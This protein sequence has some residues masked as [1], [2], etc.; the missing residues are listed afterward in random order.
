MNLDGADSLGQ[1]AKCS[2][3][4]WPINGE[5]FVRVPD[6]LTM[7]IQISVVRRTEIARR[8]EVISVT[9]SQTRL[10]PCVTLPAMC[11]RFTRMFQWAELVRLLRL[12]DI[13]P[14]EIARSYNVAPTQ[15]SP[16]AMCNDA[17]RRVGRF[18]RWGLVPS[19]APDMS[20]PAR[21][22]NARAET[23]ATKP[24]FREAFKRRRCLVPVSGY[25]EWQ[26]L[27]DGKTKQ[28]HWIGRRDRAPIMLA[29]IWEQWGAAEPVETF[30]ILTTRP[31]RLTIPIHDRTPVV[32]SEADHAAWLKPEPLETATAARLFEPYEDPEWESFPVSTAV[33]SPRNDSEELMTRIP[34]PPSTFLF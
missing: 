7:S 3:A 6:T 33:N 8:G 1:F 5:H 14:E 30:A 12:L 19:W 25:Y 13:P 24:T 31:N 10:Q 15:A 4:S 23:V 17:G 27:A 32:V 18:M 9:S 34:D 29:G 21:T 20:S 16:V 26:V 11:G 28:P 22:I 2:G